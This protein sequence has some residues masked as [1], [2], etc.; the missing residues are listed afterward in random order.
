MSVILESWSFRALRTS[1]LSPGKAGKVPN[2][3]S[4]AMANW[5]VV[6]VGGRVM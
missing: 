1:F 6:A 2:G 4:A 5:S 3:I